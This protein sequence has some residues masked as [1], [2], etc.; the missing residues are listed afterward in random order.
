MDRMLKT[1][2]DDKAD[3][4]LFSNFTTAQEY[5]ESL[6]LINVPLFSLNII[7]AYLDDSVNISSI[8]GIL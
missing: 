4:A 3:A 7:A 1:V 8:D 5:S 2:L 6:E